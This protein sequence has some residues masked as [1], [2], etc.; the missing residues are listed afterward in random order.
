MN[1]TTYIPLALRTEKPMPNVVA[2][3]HHAA[4]GLISETGELATPVKRVI[5]Y[6]K[7]MDA[8]GDD[9]KSLRDHMH[10][11][12]GDICW[13]VAIA[14]DASSV[15]VEMLSVDGS[16]SIVAMDDLIEDL[17]TYVGR[18]AGAVRDL[19]RSNATSLYANERSMV[20]NLLAN[21]MRLVSSFCSSIGVKL[22]ELLDANIAKLQGSAGRYPDGYSDAAAEARADK[23]GLDARVS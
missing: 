11:E 5:M 17:S 9:G 4:L 12:L 7:S 8:K 14:A 15:D 23:G 2:R 10:E 16:H 3:L 20:N 19:R 18:F 6:G 21:I 1:L 13:Y 22:D